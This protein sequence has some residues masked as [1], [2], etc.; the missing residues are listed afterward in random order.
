MMQ[1]YFL[2]NKHQTMCVFDVFFRQRDKTHYCVFAGLSQLIDFIQNISFSKED[3][4]Y[5]AST[6][7]FDDKFLCALRNFRFEGDIDSVVEGEIIF[8]QQPIVKVHAPIWQ[9]QFIE[10]ALLNIIG[11]Q[12]L[13]ASR[14]SMCR[15][16]AGDRTIVEFGLRRSHGSTAG[17]YASRASFIGGV[18]ATSNVLAGQQFD[19][20]IKGSMSHSYVLSFD[21][22]LEAFE[23]Y[24]KN[25]PNH[26]L[27]L[28][29]T[30]D[31]LYSGLPNAIKVFDGLKASGYNPM[32]VRIDSGDLAYLSKKIRIELD[33]AGYED[34]IIFASGDI[35][36][37][38]IDALNSQNAKVD[39]FGI[40]GKLVTGDPNPIFGVVY[41]LSSIQVDDVMQPKLK[42]SDTSQK[43]SNPGIKQLYRVYDSQ[44]MAVADI[45]AL[46][47][48]K[49][50]DPF[51]LRHP[52]ERHRTTKI[53]NYTLRNLHQ[54]IFEKGK[55]KIKIP[56]I[57]KVQEYKRNELSKFWNEYKRIVNPHIY[58]VNL[59]DGLYDLKQKLI[60]QSKLFKQL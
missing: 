28:L 50:D 27:L 29:D 16:A 20:P 47:G 52:T 41:K 6:K 17:L 32:G 7:L 43:T 57:S 58:K 54:K 49:F 30:F 39:A 3:L 44:G 8:P 51:T 31:T 23:S 56:D 36:E 4:K 24:A 37:F 45:I 14:A 40:G 9:A 25:Y 26:C 35:D 60:Y 33:K 13:V 59:S 55:L 46:Q 2:Q 38:V 53:T 42:I 19:I 18:D 1:G 21:T 11:F 22:E 48:E 10:T 5:L 34:T 15:Q 12:S